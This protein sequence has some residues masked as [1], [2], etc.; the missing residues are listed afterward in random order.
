MATRTPDQKRARRRRLVRVAGGVVLAVMLA[1][2]WVWQRTLPLERIDVVGAEYAPADEVIALT[3]AVPDSVA[4]FSLAP[5]LIADRAQRHPW[6]AT[7]SA[8][9]LPTGTLRIAVEERVPVVLVLDDAGRASHFLDADG[10]AMPADAASPA[11][12]DVPVLTGAPDYHPA[13]PVADAG[14]RS[15][16]A[17]LAQADEATHALV[18]DV[19]WGRRATLWTTPVAGHGSVPV[20]L[21]TDAGHDDQLRRLRAFWDQAV[22][23]QPD[24]RFDVVD[25]RFDG[26]VVTR[27]A[28]PGAPTDSTAAEAATPPA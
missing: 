22:L 10:F 14:L 15:F 17:A 2:A 28:G 12:F 26:Q 19:E 16:L 20:R 4:L 7:A 24:V 1:A 23:P 6:V 25:L 9:R 13:Q 3:R 5:A 8:R 21:A 27:E 18:S 11:L